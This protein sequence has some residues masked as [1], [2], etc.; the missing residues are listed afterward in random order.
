MR[1][2][3]IGPVMARRARVTRSAA[4]RKAV[5]VGN[6]ASRGVGAARRATMRTASAAAVG[7]LSLSRMRRRDAALLAVLFAALSA[8]AWLSVRNSSLM[9]VRTVKV[10]GLSGH[11]DRAAREAVVAETMAMTTMNLDEDRL[12][13]TAGRFVDVAD[14]RVDPDYP[15]GVTVFLRVRRPVA[16]VK[17]GA[18]IY[19]VSGSGLVLDSARGLGALPNFNADGA[20]IEGR[21]SDRRALEAVA[22]LGAAPD[23][24]LRQV[25]T[26]KRER[27][28]LVLVLSKGVRLLFG[29]GS[30]AAAKWR[31]AVAVLAASGTQGAAYLD[32]RV[33]QR[34]ALGG[35]GPAPVTAKPQPLERALPADPNGAQAGSTGA[36]AAQPV[37]APHAD[38]PAQSPVGSAPGAVTPAPVGST[39]A[40]GQ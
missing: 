40:L 32:L 16:A 21:L 34:P 17:I 33:P 10:V 5:A 13:Q 29:N 2:G 28:G 9:E 3:T 18:R 14:V 1:S 24:L 39:P 12:A 25:K 38:Q 11:Y 35:L 31:A 23:V 8:V 6:V 37:A 15:H 4:M 26:I 36:T 22:V 20:V 27:K 19:A 30:Q 7:A